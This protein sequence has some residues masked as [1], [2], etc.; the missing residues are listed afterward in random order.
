MRFNSLS[1]PEQMAMRKRFMQLDGGGLMSSGSPLVRQC[2]SCSKLFAIS[3]HDSF[4]CHIRAHLATPSPRIG[5]SMAQCSSSPAPRLPL[6]PLAAAPNA[7]D[8]SSA[9]PLLPPGLSSVGPLPP[10][11]E[12]PAVRAI[13][14]SFDKTDAIATLQALLRAESASELRS[15]LDELETSSVYQTSPLLLVALPAARERLER[16]IAEVSAETA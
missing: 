16:L 7:A 4:R 8:A 3:D 9:L 1:R 15:A 6:A 2:N 14:P 5:P 13:A 12:R 10:S 11:L